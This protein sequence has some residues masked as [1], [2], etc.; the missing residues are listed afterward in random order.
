MESIKY[1][2][3]EVPRSANPLYQTRARN[4]ARPRCIRERAAHRHCDRSQTRVTVPIAEGT[5]TFSPSRSGSRPG[6]IDD[7]AAHAHGQQGIVLASGDVNRCGE[8]HANGSFGFHSALDVHH[9]NQT[10]TLPS[11]AYVRDASNNRGCC[12][13]ASRRALRHAQNGTRGS[14]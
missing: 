13:A 1:A 8:D 3:P 11:N 7:D 5:P 6:R 9:S 2:R 4:V 10:D 12:G 14:P